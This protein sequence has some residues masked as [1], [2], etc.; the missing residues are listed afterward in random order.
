MKKLLAWCLTALMTLSLTSCG[1]SA[2]G[3]KPDGVSDTGGEPV[4]IHFFNAIIENVDWYEDVIARFESENPGIKVEMEFQKDYDAALKVKFQTGDVPEI[5]NGGSSQIY[6]DQGRFLDLSDMNQWW[7]RM[8]PGMKEVCTDYKTGKQFFI[9]TN[10][11]SFGL[12]YNKDVYE[13]LGLSPAKT[14]DEFVANLQAIKEANPEMA[15][16]Y[17]GSKDAW[18]LGQ[19]MDVWGYSPIRQEHGNIETKKAMIEND[20]TI[21]N[22]SAPGS[23]PQMFADAV[24][25]LQSKELFNSDFL[26]ATYDN[27]LEA[28]ANGKAA[29]LMQ[30]LWAVSLIQEK[31]PEFENI[32]FAPLP[33]L[34]EDGQP[35]MLNA[36]DVKYFI[37]A[38]SAHPEEAKV[39]LDYL[40]QAELQ[41]EFTELRQCPSAFKDVDADWGMMKDDVEAALQ[42][43]LIVDWSDAPIGFA[44]DDIG[45][46]VQDLYSGKYATSA[47]FAAE[48]AANFE[49]C[50]T[51]TY[52]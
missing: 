30:G 24:L 42:E 50:W 37:G 32:G 12:L 22:F 23:A 27:A 41:K 19:M 1:T 17:V 36:P 25:D 28:F 46:M 2:A 33:A 9:T 38:E 8:L 31:N 45:R 14:Y 15:P 34:A 3:S 52:Q 10:T 40:F 43:A 6:I 44:P 16:L 39:F 21:L 5:I 4:T 13:Q 48:Y 47:E 35:V 29:N 26:T 49:K 20:Q 11:S 18:M 51:A 7:D